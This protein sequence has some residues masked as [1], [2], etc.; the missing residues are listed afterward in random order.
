MLQLKQILIV[1]CKSS[2]HWKRF[3]FYCIMCN[4][5]LNV[6]IMVFGYGWK[7][8]ELPYN[9]EYNRFEEKP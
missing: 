8:Y 3:V 9:L 6:K 1:N 5:S 2:Y 4:F 7:K